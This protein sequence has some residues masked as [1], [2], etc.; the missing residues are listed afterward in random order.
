LFAREAT[1]GFPATRLLLLN[2][3]NKKKT[4]NTKKRKKREK[5]NGISEK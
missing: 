1:R 2:A 4:K 5:K 3:T